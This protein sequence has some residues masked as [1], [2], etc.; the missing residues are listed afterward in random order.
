MNI[1]V[2]TNSIK[3]KADFCFLGNF[4]NSQPIFLIYA[5]IISQPEP[6]VLQVL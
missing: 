5:D 3:V 6:K 4:I 1:N 2:A